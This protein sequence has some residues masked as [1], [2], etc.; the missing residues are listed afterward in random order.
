MLLPPTSQENVSESVAQ[1]ASLWSARLLQFTSLLENPT[2]NLVKGTTL[3]I[4]SELETDSFLVEMLAYC[5]PVGDK[6]QTNDDK[7][8]RII[9]RLRSTVGPDSSPL[10]VQYQA[11]S[12]EVLTQRLNLGANEGLFYELVFMEGS[13]CLAENDAL[14]VGSFLFEYDSEYIEFIDKALSVLF[15][16]KNNDATFL[17]PVDNSL[18]SV[19]QLKQSLHMHS[20]KHSHMGSPLLSQFLVNAEQEQ[21]KRDTFCWERVLPLLEFL[22]TWTLTTTA[23]PSVPVPRKRRSRSKTPE[24][25]SVS[26]ATASL[27]VKLSP[28]LI[29]ECLK[30]REED[31]LRKSQSASSTKNTTK[32][33]SNSLTDECSG[34]KQSIKESEIDLEESR[35]CAST[36]ASEC[37]KQR[38]DDHLGNSQSPSS[39]KSNNSNLVTD[40]ECSSKKPS[41]KESK[42][43]LAVS[44]NCASTMASGP[45]LLIQLPPGI[46]KVRVQY[47]YGTCTVHV[48][49]MYMY[50]QYICLYVSIAALHT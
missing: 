41:I 4:L 40:E 18:L 7:L 31:H 2:Q 44:R 43:D 13:N 14:Q 25:E 47:M 36:T 29:V 48:L 21:V 15:S 20:S 42:R 10:S 49:Y 28:N 16:E 38:D 12:Q 6:S 50:S 39:I 33:H 11:K 27:K 17:S 22:H 45:P 32:T 8:D 26:E 46:L 1:S 19:P 9:A 24:H 35:S 34:K 5:F 30:Q 37:L 3:T 23:P